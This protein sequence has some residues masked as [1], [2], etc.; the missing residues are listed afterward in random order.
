LSVSNESVK[1]ATINWCNDT[2]QVKSLNFLKLW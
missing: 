1:A 2:M